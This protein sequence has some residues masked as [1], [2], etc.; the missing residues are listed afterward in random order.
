MPKIL[1]ALDGKIVFKMS[2]KKA[3]NSKK[4]DFDIMLESKKRAPFDHVIAGNFFKS[5]KDEINAVSWHGF[6]KEEDAEKIL[7]PVVHFK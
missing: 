7:K 6:Y 4:G 5:Y 1:L 2:I 3:K